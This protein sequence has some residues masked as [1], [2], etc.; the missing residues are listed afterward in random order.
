M[1]DRIPPKDATTPARRSGD[2]AVAAFSATGAPDAG[3]R[4]RPGA[5]G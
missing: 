3:R 4:R 1:A 2:G 5:A